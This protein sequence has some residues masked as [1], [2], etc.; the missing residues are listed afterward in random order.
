M[1]LFINKQNDSRSELQ[2][3]LAQELTDKARKKAELENNERP[4][5]VDDSAFVNNTKTTSK[6]AWFWIA[7][8]VIVV[9]VVVFLAANPR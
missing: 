8:F 9:G 6:L 4:D 7:V 2:R 1:G 5:G 3:R